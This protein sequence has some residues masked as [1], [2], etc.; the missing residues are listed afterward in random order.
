[1]IDYN[2]PAG[3]ILNPGEYLVIANDQAA[4]QANI[5]AARIIGNFSDNLPNSGGLIVLKDDNNNP[6]TRF[7][8]TMAGVGRHC[9]RRRLEPGAAR[10]GCRQCTGGGLDR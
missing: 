1:M 5:L 9:R 3:T 8:T 10:P 7:A 2:I 4:L 6:P